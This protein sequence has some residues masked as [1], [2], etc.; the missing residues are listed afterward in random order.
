MSRVLAIDLGE[1]RIG[2]AVSDPTGSIAGSLRT[3]R[4]D[5]RAAELAVIRGLIA[6]QDVGRVVVGMPLAMGGGAGVQAELTRRWVA[7]L[8][9][10]LTV[11]VETL[12][13]RLTTVQA[14]RT[15]DAMGIKHRRH[16]RHVDAMA[17]TLLLQTYLDRERGS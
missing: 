1:Q 11:P 10:A 9:A 5:E 16:G 13:E 8:R 14:H 4:R 6:E 3:I 15:L 17:A 2:L 7:A 12:D